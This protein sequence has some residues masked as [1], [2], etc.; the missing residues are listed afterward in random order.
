MWADGFAVYL[1]SYEVRLHRRQDTFGG[2][3]WPV[4]PSGR[5]PETRQ[6]EIAMKAM[7][8]RSA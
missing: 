7:E 6:L 3:L 4:S 8:R 2:R 5:I 1:A